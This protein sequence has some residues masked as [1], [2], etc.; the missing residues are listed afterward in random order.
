MAKHHFTGQ[1][2]AVKKKELCFLSLKAP[3]LMHGKKMVKHRFTG[4]THRVIRRV[5]LKYPESSANME[6]KNDDRHSIFRV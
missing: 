3:M 4:Q 5:V 1:L 6:P 2:S